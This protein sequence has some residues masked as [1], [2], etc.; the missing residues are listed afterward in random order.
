MIRV[1]D[2]SFLMILTGIL[3]WLTNARPMAWDDLVFAGIINII[4][5]LCI[6]GVVSIVKEFRNE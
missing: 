6:K 5:V 2:Y 1:L 3:L 4:I